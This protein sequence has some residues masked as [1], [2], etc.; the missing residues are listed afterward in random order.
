[1]LPLITRLR[2]LCGQISPDMQAVAEAA[3]VLNVKP[4]AFF[5]VAYRRWYGREA[6]NQDRAGR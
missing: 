6:D 2:R 1:M 5:Q 4:Y 3:F